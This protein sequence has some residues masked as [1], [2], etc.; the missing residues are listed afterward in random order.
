MKPGYLSLLLVIVAVQLHAQPLTKLISAEK[1]TEAHK[2]LHHTHLPDSAANA[3]VK[4]EM[5]SLSAFFF[6]WPVCW[7]T[8]G[9]DVIPENNMLPNSKADNIFIDV[10]LLGTNCEAGTQH[11]NIVS[12]LAHQ[13]A[14]MMLT[15]YQLTLSESKKRIF[16]D[17]VAG[18]YLS[19]RFVND[20]KGNNLG[21]LSDYLDQYYNTSAD[22][23][24]TSRGFITGAN[25]FLNHYRKRQMFTLQDIIY[26]G[27]EVASNSD[28]QANQL[29]A[30]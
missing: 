25:D 7:Y 28:M 4:T 15:K 8:D 14:A 3:I 5:Q 20:T 23:M 13:F 18:Y 16:T 22:N 11:I 21:W 26:A 17:Y 2:V 6:K 30:E 19:C 10:N 1:T 12:I 24:A 9:P 29:S 27:L